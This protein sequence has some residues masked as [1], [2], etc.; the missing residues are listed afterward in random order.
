MSQERKYDMDIGKKS[1][2]A[3]KRK[4]KTTTK[5]N[6]LPVRENMPASDKNDARE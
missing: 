1:F 2:E 5:N 3:G 6:R 4:I